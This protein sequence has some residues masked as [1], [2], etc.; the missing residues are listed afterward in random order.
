[1]GLLDG[2]TAEQ[3]ELLLFRKEL[4][5]APA[6]TVIYRVDDTAEKVYQVVSGRVEFT[7]TAEDGTVH[8]TGTAG[9]GDLFGLP[10]LLQ[11]V[12][13][14]ATTATTLEP[15]ELSE[16]A[17][18]SL[19]LLLQRHGPTAVATFQG[20][21]LKT[22]AAQV[23]RMVTAA[24]EI[25]GRARIQVHP[26]YPVEPGRYLALVEKALPGGFMAKLFSSN[27]YRAG[28]CLVAEGDIPKAAYFLR[29]G[30]VRVLNRA[31]EETHRCEAPDLIAE[32]GYLA[33][34]PLWYTLEVATDAELVPLTL[35]DMEAF[36][37][38]NPNEGVAL[39]DAVARL[40]LL[41]YLTVEYRR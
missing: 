30:A 38:K 5:N 26:D 22:L 39:Y 41:D 15:T 28:T 14:R 12:R 17:T 10:A 3:C 7:M 24:A 33:G 23:H 1:M 27:S 11:G 40:L 32:V 16:F 37:R 19:E 31:G 9:P 34:K 36:C 21:F 13:F 2:L 25:R 8:V 4:W 29:S 6:G 18:D 20:N 35:K